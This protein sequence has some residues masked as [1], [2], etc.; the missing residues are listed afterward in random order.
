MKVYRELAARADRGETCTLATVI[1]TQ[2]SSP[3]EASMKMLA[4]SEGRITG[5]VGGGRV[6]AEVEQA[7]GRVLESGS[8]ETL[9]FTLDDD[10][11]DEGGLICGGTVRILVERVDPPAG[12]AAAVVE[13][14][15]HG[16]RAALIARIGETVERE[17]LLD[18]EA[19]PW[20]ADELPRL[21]GDRFVEP[22]FRPRCILLGAGHVG[23]AVARVAREAG[24][25]VTAVEDR[26]EQAARAEVDEVVIAEDLVEGLAGLDPNA[27]DFILVLTR[28]H[29]MDFRCAKAALASP[30]RWVG[31]LA[32]K[33]KAARLREE[34][35]PAAAARLES[36]VG[37]EIGASSAG[38]IAVSIV[39][40]MI[41]VK[42]AARE[43][44]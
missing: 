37:L 15:R 43:G 18:D 13:A 35:D 5:T 26:P 27:Q 1:D 40:R 30:A 44:G 36:P 41:R 10:M 11:A 14:F 12:W 34:L 17:L 16:R 29:G 28:S 4:G 25:V 21:D 24:F 6:E 8:P 9:S 23:R 39:A 32:S 22:I 7:A 31:M 42:R 3:A 20:I 2:G 19:D 33:K 38:E